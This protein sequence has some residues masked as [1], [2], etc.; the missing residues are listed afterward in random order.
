MLLNPTV[1]KK[2]LTKLILISLLLALVL[3]ATSFG[4]ARADPGWYTSTWAYRKKITIDSTKVTADLTNFPVLINLSSDTDLAS[5]AQD[6]G[7]DILFTESDG[8]TQLSH[9]IEKFDGGTGQ[10]VAWVKIPSLSSTSNTEI[11]LYYGNSGASNQQNATA[12]W[13]SNYRMVQHLEE[14][15]GTIYDST[16]NN[17]DGTASN[18]VNQNATG[19]IDG[20]NSFD[21]VDDLV[22]YGSDNS[23]KMTDALTIELWVKRPDN[24]TF[25][26]FLSHSSG[27]NSYAYEVGV[28]FTETNK[29]RFRLNS[30]AITLK[31]AMV[32]S[33]GQWLYLVVTYDKNA[34]GTTE[35]KMYEN[36]SSIGTQ[37]YS[38]AMTNHGNL[39]TNR[40]GKTDGWCKSTIDE[41]RI[42]DTARSANW[43]STSYNNQNSP[44]TFYSLGSEEAGAAVPVG[45]PVIPI[46]KLNV[47][48]PWLGLMVALC[49]AVGGSML[50]VRRTRVIKGRKKAL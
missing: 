38:T 11:Y 39:K 24:T 41:V 3:M 13:D 46:N 35:M 45:A 27:V 19:K 22:D 30:D 49:L 43:I 8:T 31:S 6:D 18:G 16:S 1:F 48:A 17:N 47:L 4:V 36:G 21:G 33:P 28:D 37:D 23:L 14:T 40:Q 44:S 25:E 34:G 9:E 42:S 5:D 26:R 12:V 50:F 7:D 20:A 29:W 10:L 15:T 32:G 2:R